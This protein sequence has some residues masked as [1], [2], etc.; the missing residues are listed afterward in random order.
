[1]PF[2]T[3]NTFLIIEKTI[4]QR[5]ELII[6]SNVSSVMMDESLSKSYYSLTHIKTYKYLKLVLT[7]YDSDFDKKK[8]QQYFRIELYGR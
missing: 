2:H 5:N 8:A 4:I 7:T 6:S 3:I 1:M